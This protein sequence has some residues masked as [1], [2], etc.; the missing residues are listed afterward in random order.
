M[1]KIIKA[2]QPPVP[3]HDGQL[4]E[5]KK[6]LKKDSVKVWT[7]PVNFNQVV[8]AKHTVEAVVNLKKNGDVLEAIEV[9]CPCG[10][11]IEILCQYD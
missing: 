5:M 3:A 2:T 7:K 6:I 1:K 9:I 8:H 11:K 10:N 4:V